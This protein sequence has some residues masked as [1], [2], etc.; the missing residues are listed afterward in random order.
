MTFHAVTFHAVTFQVVP[1]RRIILLRDA[2]C[3]SSREKG[4]MRPMVQKACNQQ[5]DGCSRE[6]GLRSSAG[7]CEIAAGA[8]LSLGQ[9]KKPRTWRG[10]RGVEGGPRSAPHCVT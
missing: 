10:L 5:R 1:A 9:K 8:R 6:R 7:G 4:D 3:L 2:S